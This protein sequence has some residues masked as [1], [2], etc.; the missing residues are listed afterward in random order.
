MRVILTVVTL[1]AM[2]CSCAAVQHEIYGTQVAMGPCKSTYIAWQESVEKLG[3]TQ[4]RE[5][6]DALLQC[7]RSN[8]VQGPIALVTSEVYGATPP[9]RFG[10]GQPRRF[11][12]VHSL[13]LIASHYSP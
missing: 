10:P 9:P 7:L 5:P 8:G 2:M 11:M 6:A 13:E 12:D 3:R 1:S 4:A